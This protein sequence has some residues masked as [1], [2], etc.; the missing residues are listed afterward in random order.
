KSNKGFFLAIPTP[1]APK[2]GTDGKRINPTNFP[3]ASVGKLRFVYRP[4]AVSL[5]VVDDLSARTGMRGGFR[6]ASAAAQRSGRVTTVPMFFLV[7][8][9]TMK[10][11]LD[12]DMVADKWQDSLPEKIIANWPDIKD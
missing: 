9:V 7:P 3:E 10:K 1:S 6:M 5:L 12:I 4:G 11:K 8:Q 2:R